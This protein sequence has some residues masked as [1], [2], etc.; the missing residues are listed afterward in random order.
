MQNKA[1]ARDLS[2]TVHNSFE[3]I[4]CSGWN[5]IPFV[6]QNSFP[7]FFCSSLGAVN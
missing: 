2:L 7:A 3:W 6:S 1:L 4:S 5:W